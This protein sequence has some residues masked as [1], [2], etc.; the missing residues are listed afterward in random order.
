MSNFIRQYVAAAELLFLALA[1]QHWAIYGYYFLYVGVDQYLWQNFEEISR[2]LMV[3]KCL[4]KEWKQN[5]NFQ[6]NV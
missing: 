6:V 5:G 4:T 3:N 1:D 2:L